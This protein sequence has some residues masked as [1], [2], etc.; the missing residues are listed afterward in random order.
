MLDSIDRR[1]WRYRLVN[2]EVE[3]QIFP[4]PDDV[5]AGQGWSDTP[6]GLADVVQTLVSRGVTEVVPEIEQP[7]RRGRP[8]KA[9]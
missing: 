1:C 9:K 4:S 7:K 8:A 2:G 6:A 3:K 5:P